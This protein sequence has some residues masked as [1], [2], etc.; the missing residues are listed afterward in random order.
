MHAAR[1][2]IS[3]TFVFASLPRVNP[4]RTDSTDRSHEPSDCAVVPVR[5]TALVFTE[6][7]RGVGTQHR[8]NPGS[9]RCPPA[10]ENRSALLDAAVAVARSEP[11][12][13]T[14]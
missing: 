4:H 14:Y 8:L 11:A 9:T 13:T 7:P 5:S 3:L 6:T 1:W 2:V 10:P 12:I